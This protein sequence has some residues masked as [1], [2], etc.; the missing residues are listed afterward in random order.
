MKLLIGM[1]LACVTLSGCGVA[2]PSPSAAT[3]NTQNTSARIFAIRRAGLERDW[4]AIP[5]LIALLDSS[6]PAERMWSIHALEEITGERLG[7]QPYAPLEDRLARKQAWETAWTTG[8]LKPRSETNTV[9]ADVAV[10]RQGEGL[11]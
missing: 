2:G 4:S 6:D 11:K 10:E 8:D 1:I 7:Y 5:R 3:F 9:V